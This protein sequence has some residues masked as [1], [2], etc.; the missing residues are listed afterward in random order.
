MRSLVVS[1]CALFIVCGCGRDSQEPPK[2]ALNSPP[3]ATNSTPQTEKSPGANSGTNPANS[4]IVPAAAQAKQGSPTASGPQFA[5][6][7]PEQTLRW[8]IRSAAKVRAAPRGEKSAVES[9]WKEYTRALKTAN[10]RK[11][12]WEMRVKDVN[13]AGAAMETVRDPASA[14]CGGLRV[15]PAQQPDDG[16]ECFVLEVPGGPK[17]AGL[18]PGTRALVTGVVTRIDS[19]LRKSRPHI[20]PYEFGVRLKDYTVTPLK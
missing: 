1:A 10:G 11:I 8:L 18:S 4:Q 14:D 3:G 15:K 19:T 16:V 17:A 7:S 12:H 5:A 13:E 20:T 6:D 2:A 9:A